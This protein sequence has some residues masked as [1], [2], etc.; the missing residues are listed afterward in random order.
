MSIIP[1]GLALAIEDLY[2]VFAKYPPISPGPI[3]CIDYGGTQ[4]E[5]LHFSTVSL[6]QLDAKYIA[7]LEFYDPSWQSWGSENEVK[8]LLP[9]I[10]ECI[11]L[12]LEMLENGGV[13]GLF[14]YKM[15]D[16]F[17]ERASK[18]TKDESQA[19]RA[20]LLQLFEEAISKV[21]NLNILLEAICCVIDNM[22]PVLTIWDKYSSDLK[23]LQIC[24]WLEY[25]IEPGS[26]ALKTRLPLYC[27]HRDK[28]EQILGWIMN[29]KNSS[30]YKILFEHPW[31]QLT[32]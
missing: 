15:V 18:W 17:N 25:Y 1:S 11:A 26:F 19:I 24:N 16:V 31:W 14:K 32:T 20:Y 13:F 23:Y 29:N 12:N 27:S 21:E 3:N 7:R 6:R 30:T 2:Q 9:R 4:E 10:M 5:Q 8:Y 28:L 22:A